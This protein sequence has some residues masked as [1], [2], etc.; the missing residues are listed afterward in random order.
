MFFCRRCV[1]VCISC[2]VSEKFRNWFFMRLLPTRFLASAHHLPTYS[3][4]KAPTCL[5]DQLAFHFLFHPSYGTLYPLASNTHLATM[6]KGVKIDL[7]ENILSSVCAFPRL[8]SPFPYRAIKQIRNK[9]LSE[10]RT[11]FKR[12]LNYFQQ[13]EEACERE[14]I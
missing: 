1:K 11:P 8:S 2:H 12:C 10:S 13:T 5:W 7:S 9:F 14:T 6:L 4:Y 3:Q